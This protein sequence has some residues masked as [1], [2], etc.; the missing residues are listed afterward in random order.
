MIVKLSQYHYR[1]QRV[2]LVERNAVSISPGR[3]CR[4]TVVG[5]TEAS[6]ELA[7]RITD[8]PTGR[9]SRPSLNVL[10]QISSWIRPQLVSFPLKSHLVTED[11]S[12]HL[13]KINLNSVCLSFLRSVLFVHIKYVLCLMSVPHPHQNVSSLSAG[14]LFC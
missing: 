14:I 2:L 11:F 7:Y 6:Q 5:V 3:R 12:G 4:R 13:C 10:P 1:A 8:G 9:L